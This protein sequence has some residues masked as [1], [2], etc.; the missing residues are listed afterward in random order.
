MTVDRGYTLT[1]LEII[2]SKSSNEAIEIHI[3]DYIDIIINEYRKERVIKKHKVPATPSLFKV[4]K[5]DEHHEIRK[6]FF[7]Y[8]NHKVTIYP[9]KTTY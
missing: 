1:Y 5:K 7:P 8:I 3:P 6:H 4:T 2:L 9:L